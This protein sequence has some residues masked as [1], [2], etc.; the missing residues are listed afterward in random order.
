[1]LTVREVYAEILAAGTRYA[2]STVFKTMQRMKAPAGRSPWTV[3][4]Q[5]GADFRVSTET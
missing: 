2:A 1:V 5:T 4:E 3:L